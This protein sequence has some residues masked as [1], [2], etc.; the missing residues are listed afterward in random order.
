MKAIAVLSCLALAVVVA[1][2]GHQH[3]FFTRSTVPKGW[4][5]GAA[6]PKNA[7]VNF[8]VALKQRNLEALEALFWAV[9]TPGNPQ[10]QD[11]QTTEAILDIVAPEA[12]CHDDVME[13][14]KAAGKV[15]LKSTRDAIEVHT[16]VGVAEKLFNTKFHVFRHESRK[17]IVKAWGAM[18]MPASVYQYVDMIEGISTFPIPHLSYKITPGDGPSA[19]VP[20]TLNTIYSIPPQTAGAHPETSVGVIEFQ[21]QSYSPADSVNFANDVAIKVLPVTAA[22]TIGPNDPTNPQIEAAL[23]IEMVATVNPSATAWFWLEDGQG[24]LYQ[25]VNHYFNTA[26]VPQV[27]SISYGWSE[28]DQCDIDP[29]ECQSL[30][31]T[32]QQY[33]ARVNAEFQKIAAQGRTILVASGDSGANGRTDPDCTLP[34]LK[35]DYPAASPY[36]TSVGATQLDSPVANLPNPPPVCVNQGYSCASGG[37]EHAVS[38]AVAN[39]ASG[40]GFSNVAPMPSYQ[41]AAVA[42]YLKSGVALPP[43]GYYNTTGRGYPDVAAIGNA[44]LIDQGG[45][46]P[47]GGTSASAPEWAAV[48]SILNQASIKKNNKP[49][50]FLNPWIYQVAAACKA[51]FTDIIVGDNICTEDGCSA[52]CQGFK[53]TTGWDPVTGWGSPVVSQLINYIN[54]H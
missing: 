34:Y 26:N 3:V 48:V 20:Q 33:V 30:G 32:S 44:V 1:A 38:Y 15:Q 31:V 25:Y 2:S 47:V 27:V 5:K 7:A 53:C 10:Y 16:S 36:I 28:A 8:M 17:P 12:K 37:L 51:C 24:W 22:N 42:A 19:I 49:L 50:G 29:D 40:G 6:A 43:V 21:G 54:T 18:S 41:S 46:Q 39:F 52:G 14:L 11:F 13:W 35:P 45:V 4:T 23:D 9:S